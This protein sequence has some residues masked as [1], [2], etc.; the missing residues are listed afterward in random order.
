MRTRVRVKC[1]DHPLQSSIS[2]QGLQADGSECSQQ[3]TSKPIS[4][5]S[6]V[7]FLPVRWVLGASLRIQNRGLRN[8]LQNV[9]VRAFSGAPVVTNLPYKA[10]V[11]GSIPGLGPRFPHITEHLSPCN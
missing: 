5:L 1:P 7:C 6:C 11:L 3:R 2:D 10:G 8:D 9:L 4:Q